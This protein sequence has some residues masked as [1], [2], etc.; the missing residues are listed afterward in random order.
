MCATRPLSAGLLMVLVEQ[1][2]RV[3]SSALKGTGMHSTL[4]KKLE[5]ETNPKQSGRTPRQ[6]VMI[7]ISL[8]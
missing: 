2:L 7:Y 6:L 5:N 4:N 3:G 1:M 8:V